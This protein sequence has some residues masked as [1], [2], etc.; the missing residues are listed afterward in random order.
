[1]VVVW[2]MN[3]EKEYESRLYSTLASHDAVLYIKGEKNFPLCGFSAC[4]ISILKRYDID[5]FCENILKDY[6][7]YEWLKETNKWPVLPHVY[8]GGE[9]IGGYDILKSLHE[10]GELMSMLGHARRENR[11]CAA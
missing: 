1:M 8:I 6:G 11:Y 3:K 10:S 7:F 4:S 5:L 2:S 9:F